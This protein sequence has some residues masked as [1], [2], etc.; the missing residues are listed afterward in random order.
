MRRLTKV[1]LA[2]VALTAGVIGLD[3]SAGAGQTTT[4]GG[5]AHSLG[6]GGRT[7]NGNKR[8]NQDCT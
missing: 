6:C 4:A 7:S 3:G 2:L 1:A 5:P 8:V